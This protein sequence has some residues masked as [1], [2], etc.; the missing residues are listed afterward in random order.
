[1]PRPPRPGEVRPPKEHPQ[2]RKLTAWQKPVSLR[3]TERGWKITI[4]E[5]KALQELF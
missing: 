1:M 4:A 5:R 2:G 3:L